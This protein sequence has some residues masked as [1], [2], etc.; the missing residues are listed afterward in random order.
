MKI[1]ISLIFVSC[2]LLFLGNT[3][4]Q[5]M[6][7]H[8]ETA[9][10][11]LLRDAIKN[12]KTA[13]LRELLDT[14]N[15][16]LTAVD[17]IGN[18]PLHEAAQAGHLGI[19]AVLLDHAEQHNL[20]VHVTMPNERSHAE[21]AFHYSNAFL[22]F[23][24]NLSLGEDVDAETAKT[25]DA[26]A[27]IAEGVVEGFLTGFYSLDAD[28]EERDRAS[29]LVTIP[30]IHMKNAH[31]AT[32][33]H[34][35]IVAG[36]K[37]CVRLLIDRGANFEV[38]AH[39][40]KKFASPCSGRP[41]HLACLGAHEEIAELL[42][43]RGADIKA[44]DGCKRSALHCAALGGSQRLA[45]ILIDKGLSPLAVDKQ[46]RTP[47]ACAREAG[48]YTLAAFFLTYKGNKN[49][50]TQDEHLTPMHFAAM[51]NDCDL[52]NTLEKEGALLH[53]IDSNGLQPIHHAAAKGACRMLNW[54]LDRAPFLLPSLSGAETL[55]CM[56]ARARQL[57]A[58]KVI[59]ERGKE[60]RPDPIDITSNSSVTKMSLT[61]GVEFNKTSYLLWAAEERLSECIEAIESKG[62]EL[63]SE[64]IALKNLWKQLRFKRNIVGAYPE[65]RQEGASALQLVAAEGH[66]KI[67]YTILKSMVA[68]TLVQDSERCYKSLCE[69][70]EI[71]QIIAESFLIEYKAHPAEKDDIHTSNTRW[72][73]IIAKAH[74]KNPAYSIAKLEEILADGRAWKMFNRYLF[75]LAQRN[76]E[77]LRRGYKELA[78]EIKSFVW[79]TFFSDEEVTSWDIE[80]IW[81]LLSASC[82]LA[83]KDA[84]AEMAD[85]VV[86][87]VEQSLRRRIFESISPEKLPKGKFIE[88]IKNHALEGIT[89][90]LRA[91]STDG[92]LIGRNASA[93]ALYSGEQLQPQI[94]HE[95]KEAQRFHGTAHAK[96]QEAAQKWR[97]SNDLYWN[98][99]H[100]ESYE[101]EVQAKALDAEKDALE[102]QAFQ[103]TSQ[104]A[105]LEEKCN[106]FVRLGATLSDASGL[107]G[108]LLAE[109]LNDI[110]TKISLA[111]IKKI[112]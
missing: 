44:V 62:V 7:K 9:C 74:A 92:K 48:H 107:L 109:W 50:Y 3:S 15:I 57:E 10:T 46:G 84:P 86:T 11:I 26:G 95:R 75:Q 96:A 105:A 60:I 38:C 13:M 39:E 111:L 28:K 100:V 76:A 55:L 23:T 90:A 89:C 22:N 63:S 110:E 81:T 73:A 24:P 88:A 98:Y 94:A 36:H 77:A 93:S 34:S 14:T 108:T 112:L 52:A 61:Y 64:M 65:I 51:G 83:F 87:L 27:F 33:L 16:S 37:E 85:D 31:G 56:A 6:V 42:I 21:R 59:I 72:K 66:E 80:K 47:I 69:E 70:A 78:P 82:W 30:F 97:E 79:P 20:R 40:N 67:F 71:K 49:S 101:V 103:H 8:A 5:A 58:M 106:Q 19:V 54:C 99:Q 91:Q 2:S 102:Q 1:P 25:I 68:H 29:S 45:K 12:G 17:Q 4:S 53:P 43:A 35:A 32:A 104:A 18:T 41:L